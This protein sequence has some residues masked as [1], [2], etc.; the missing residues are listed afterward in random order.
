MPLSQFSN[1]SAARR[2]WLGLYVQCLGVLMIVLDGTVVNVALSAIKT[3]LNFS[4]RSLIWVVNGYLI[5]YGGFLLLGGRLGDYYGYRR[6]FMLGIGLFTGAS[7]VC[8]LSCSP[9]LMLVGRM[10]QGLGAAVVLA[11]SL[12]LIL[13]QFRN[14]AE[15]AK[16]MSIFSLACACGGSAGLILGGILVRMLGWRWIFFINVPIG[17]P[18]CVLCALLLPMRPPALA[19]RRL[20]VGGALA[21]TISLMLAAYVAVSVADPIRDAHT[22]L[23]MMSSAGLFAL[24]VICE[25]RAPEPLIPFALLRD[26]NL[27]A[28]MIAGAPCVAAQS[29]WF[30]ICSLFLQQVLGYRSMQVGLSFLPVNLLI[31]AFS[32]GGSA[33]LVTRFGARPVFSV[34]SLLCGL[35]LILFS[36][37]PVEASFMLEILPGMIL[38]GLGSAVAYSSVVLAAVAAVGEG[39]YGAASGTLN[40]VLIMIAPLAIATLGGAA[41]A[42]TA[43]I[44][45]HSASAVAALAGG[46]HLAFAI[47]AILAILGAL[48]GA[49]LLPPPKSGGSAANL[50]LSSQ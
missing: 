12:S 17:I 3:D 39:N 32:F 36:F 5:P 45:V 42:R 46:Y 4:E 47:A 29:A 20:D 34:G 22:V 6:L 40:S 31:A 9:A 35:G 38:F 23:A 49:W 15:R 8:G 1:L 18:V 44:S 14:P 19:H 26:R 21:I 25:I 16:A 43:S 11:V 48:L 10:M 30:Y 33:A 24:F 2:D 28:A 13:D 37:S 41:A 27:F 50:S 7:L